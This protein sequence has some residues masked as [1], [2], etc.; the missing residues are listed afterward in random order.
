MI[1]CDCPVTIWYYVHYASKG[2]ITLIEMTN[3]THWL[4]HSFILYTGYHMFRQCPAII[5]E[6]LR[7]FWVTL[8]TNRMVG[9]LY[10]VWLCGLRAL[11]CFGSSLPSSGSFLDPS[12]LLE[13]QIEWVVYHIMCGY[14]ACVPELSCWYTTIRF[15]FKVTQMDLRSSLMMAGHCRNM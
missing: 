3:N 12:E 2:Y 14:M 9:I 4:Y 5:R 15:V 10:N 11:T 6:L 8:N 13:I 1:Q 7:S